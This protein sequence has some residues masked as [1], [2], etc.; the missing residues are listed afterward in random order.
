MSLL[1]AEANFSDHR[2]M[3]F[4]TGFSAG[5]FGEIDL[6]LRG[7]SDFRCGSHRQAVPA[8]WPQH[9]EAEGINTKSFRDLISGQKINQNP[10]LHTNYTKGSD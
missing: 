9:A 1:S 3:G 8:R 6:N 7:G 2:L 5:T 4:S 10:R